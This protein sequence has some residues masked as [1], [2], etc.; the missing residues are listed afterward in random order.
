MGDDIIIFKRSKK[1]E[2]LRKKHKKLDEIY[3]QLDVKLCKSKLPYGNPEKDKLHKKWSKALDAQRKA[4]DEYNKLLLKES[5]AFDKKH[6]EQKEL[7]EKP[8]N[9]SPKTKAMM[10]K[11]WNKVQR[12]VD[13]KW[14]HRK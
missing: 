2:A 4:W 10:S 6:P 12:D 8:L 1:C 5:E 14:A 3:Y 11:L 7:L 9:M 13:K